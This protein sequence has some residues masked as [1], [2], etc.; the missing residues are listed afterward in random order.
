MQDEENKVNAVTLKKLREIRGLSRKEAGVLLEIGYKTVEKF[1]N[2]RTILNKIR[3][4]KTVK[5][6][7]L[8]YDDFLLCREGQSEQVRERIGYKKEKAI[9]NKRGRRFHTKIIT[10]EV[11]VLQVLRILKNLSQRKASS[12][13]GYHKKAIGVIE[14]GRVELSKTKIA[15]HCKILWVHNGRF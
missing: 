6:Y 12:L 7:G 3:V 14:N 8:T 4:E 15:P 5:A 1:E 11:R 10:K 2:G 9:S 13:C